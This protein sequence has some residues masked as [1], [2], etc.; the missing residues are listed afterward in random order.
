MFKNPIR[1]SGI[2]MLGLCM[3]LALSMTVTERVQAQTLYGT[4]TGTVKDTTGG[5]IPGA[6]LTIV[7]VATNYTMTTISNDVGTYTF[8][9]VPDGTY[10][11]RVSLTG[12]KEFVAENL[13]VQVGTVYRQPVVMEV[14][15][16][17][18][19]ITVSSA[20]TVLK[21]DTTDVSAQLESEE[22]TDLPL[23]QYKN[24]QSLINLVPGTTPANFQNANTDTP[25]RSLTT[26]VNGTARNNNNTRID[27]AMSVN[28][29][30]PHHSAY[31]PPT[32]TIE[33]VNITTNNF[34]A[35]T[36]F[37]G[38]A[39]IAVVSKSGTNDLHGSAFWFHE[40]SSVA[41]RN[42]FNFGEKPKSKKNI[43]GGTI[44]GP[45]IKDKLFFFGGFEGTLDRQPG[46]AT[47]TLPNAAMRQGDFSA[48]DT[49]IYD[50]ATGNADGTGRIPFTNNI[51]PSDRLSPAAVKMANLLPPLT[52]PD[53]LTD[54][55]QVSGTSKLD[56]YNYDVKV[57]WY[58]SDEHRIWGK[59]SWMDATVTNAPRFGD[60]GGSA[61]AGAGTGQGL[62]DVK[63]YS[64]GHNFSLSPTFLMDGVFGFTDMDQVVETH[65]LDLGNY[66]QDVLGI[67][68][69]NLTDNQSCIVNGVNYCGGI[70]RF[71]VSGYTS[72]GQVDGWS[73]LVRD[74]DSFT[75]S[76][77]FSWSKEN[78]ELRFGYDLVRHMMDHWQPEIG[79]GPRGRFN[80]NREMTALKDGASP[81]EQNAWA[82]F[83]LGVPS[84]MGKSLQWELM[85]LREWQH[86]WYIRDRWQ[87]TPKLTATLGLRYEFYPLVS[88]ADRGMEYLDLNTFELVLGNNIAVSKKL[89]APRLGF[90]YRLSDDDVIRTGY[91]ITFSPLPFARP[92]RG[93]YPL[94]IAADFSADDAF[95]P[96]TDLEE[97]IPIFTGPDVAPGGRTPLPSFV[98][99]RTMPPDRI[100]RGYIQSW[101]MIY[102]RKLPSDF[103]VSIGYVGTQTTNQLADF[104]MNW[105]PAGGGNTGR[106]LYP[107][108]TTSIMYWDGWLSK[109]YHSLQTT[110]NRRFT[111]GLFVKGA[112]TWGRA[113]DMA[114]D[115]GWAGISW[116]DPALI[117]RNRAMAS[118]DRKH[119]LQLAT[120]YQLPWGRDGEGIGNWLIRDWQVNGIFSITSNSPFTIGA[121][122]GTLNARNN[123]QTAQQV[124]AW[125]IIGGIGRDQKY[126]TTSAFAPVEEVRPECTS[127]NPC[128][129]NTGRNIMRGPSWTN[130]DLSLFRTFQVSEDFGVEFRS[131]FFNITN[132]PKFG[133]P[134]GNASSSAFGE[135]RGTASFAP[136]RVIR[137]ALKL[138]F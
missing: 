19:S 22:I 129:G 72:F 70:P 85:T 1:G 4:I 124:G 101:N 102:E 138:K 24:Y 67:P 125:D 123:A 20:A 86:A 15:E 88:R 128:Y 115:E 82:S 25:G 105:S 2:L 71:S 47:N 117:H 12:F 68:G 48:F 87:I 33:V 53:Q 122:S 118:Y 11:L 131:E 132:T 107:K 18:E 28:I 75:F 42:Y 5:A 99:Q 62:T 59:F 120:V 39:A 97:G 38:G 41:A 64:V 56:R 77:N 46:T 17:T 49:I 43:G 78:H 29:W 69:T 109:N 96:F 80:F 58:Q 8:N 27:G 44:G 45:I 136:S 63:T 81:T 3:I 23:G 108:S 111:G 14:G 90:A 133:N 32:E 9:N 13:S 40:N 16:I 91:G 110:I 60:A 54:N 66:G 89:F 112:Y 52:F 127:A 10:T 74:E 26:N 55:H 50:P 57:D 73:P 65:D 7:N 126:F 93:F 103:V 34:D 100:T 116:N 135:V 121:S 61:V 76:Y 134:N 95:V 30:L 137:F 106:Q 104:N 98:Q 35:E 51:I 113:I 114:N 83:M 6:E 84:W 31:V 79:A 37:A 94:T 130:L 36:G 21:T 92:L 119:N